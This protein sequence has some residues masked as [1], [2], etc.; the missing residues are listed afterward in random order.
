MINKKPEII[1]LAA[2]KQ[3]RF[4]TKQPKILSKIKGKSIL[5]RNIEIFEG[6]KINLVI[7]K[8]NSKYFDKYKEKINIIEING[9]EG[10]GGD[11]LRVL[12]KIESDDF[13]L[14]WGDAVITDA[15]LFKIIMDKMILELIC[16]DIVFPVRKEEKPYVDFLLESN[17]VLTVFFKR[18][19]EIYRKVGWHDLSFFALN[20]KPILKYLKKLHKDRLKSEFL[21]IFNFKNK[22]KHRVIKFYN[23]IEVIESFN[24]ISQLRRIKN[25]YSF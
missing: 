10:S 3:V 18:R 16:N 6:Y 25:D 22:P 12:P 4:K 23:K 8:R 11:L 5:D 7:D 1:I 2:G 20:K 9:G 13:I 19:D 17:Q 15:E 24:T 21:D 14:I